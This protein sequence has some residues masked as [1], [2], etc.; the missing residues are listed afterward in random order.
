MFSFL[1]PTLLRCGRCIGIEGAE[2]APL[3]AC[4]QFGLV[5]VLAF[6][7]LQSVRQLQEGAEHGCAVVIGQLD[8]AGFLDEAAQL[9]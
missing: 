5:F 6:I 3:P 1:P 2:A 8:K 4:E 7:G 9:D